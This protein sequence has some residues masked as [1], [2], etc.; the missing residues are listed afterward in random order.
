VTVI[1][2]SGPDSVAWLA[3]LL[4][5]FHPL[6]WLLCLIGLMLSAL[7][8]IAAKSLFDGEPPDFSGW[9]QQ[10]LENAD[11]LRAEMLDGSLGRAIIRG[12]PLL[13][14]NTALWSLIGG[15]IAR[16]ELLAR[17]RGR[18]DGWDLFAEPNANRFLLGWWKPLLVCCPTA[19]LLALLLLVPVLVAGIVNSSLGSLGAVVVAL[20]LPVVL[21]ADLA[22]LAIAF[23]AVA[24][25][26][27]PVA[28]AAECGDHFDALSRSYTY[29]FQRPVRALLLTATAL[30]LAWLP[31]AMASALAEEIA[32][33]QPEIARAAVLLAAA[34]S[35][36]IFWSLETLVYLH[37]RCAIDGV[38]AGEVAVEPLRASPAAPSPEGKTAED[39]TIAERSPA[40]GRSLLRVTIELLIA[41]VASWC[42]TFWLFTRASR[43]QTEWL[44]WGL[45]D[46][47]VPPAEGVFYR[48]ASVIAGLWGVAWLALP[49]ASAARRSL[50]TSEKG[51]FVD[52]TNPK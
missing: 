17:Q 50:R 28:L 35:A 52:A 14:L 37:L 30:I 10:P 27:M 43:G 29:L 31:L 26:L 22:L 13:A 21:L 23:G 20:L 42:L 47:F 2:A 4:R 51:T 33:G 32:A 40:H 38:D 48:V 49:L 3:G 34:L 8:A 16:H 15:W 44:G 45:T 9:W 1:D 39:P 5:G 19:L 11:A 46:T 25:P 41:V 7:S 12:G 36:S 18:S 6:R 24:W